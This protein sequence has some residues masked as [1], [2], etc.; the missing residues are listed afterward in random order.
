MQEPI[1][2]GDE[3]KRL[4]TLNDLR[5]LDTPASDQYDRLTRLATDIYD[6]PYSEIN[7][8]DSDRQWSKSM[9]GTD[10][11]E[12][13]REISF[14]AHAI[15]EDEP[16]IV[17]DTLDDERFEDNPLVE[18]EPNIRFYASVPIAV[19][20]HTVG[21]FC[22]FGSD[23][24]PKNNFNFRPLED[25]GNIVVDKLTVRKE[26]PPKKIKTIDDFSEERR[27]KL[28]D[29][30]SRSWKKKA[31]LQLFNSEI[32]NATHKDRESGFALI[33]LDDVEDTIGSHSSTVDQQLISQ[34]ADRIRRKLPPKSFLGRYNKFTFLLIVPD[35]KR[36]QFKKVCE[37]LRCD[38]LNR[39]FALRLHSQSSNHKE[40]L[41]KVSTTCSIGSIWCNNLSTNKKNEILNKLESLFAHS[42]DNGGNEFT[43]G[44][45]RHNNFSLHVEGDVKRSKAI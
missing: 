13:D 7:L 29:S 39:R 14:C 8:I 26:R 1:T 25:L 40:K 21:S 3:N 17:P 23:P 34:F 30:T 2:P 36:N 32:N 16:F 9:C 35:T 38:I 31:I 18:G 24:K 44:T 45:V 15:L 37:Q 11:A 19:D 33:G 6:L 5:I 42:K 22:V 43:F 12:T 4:E 28:I 10:E 41:R 20:G 27:K